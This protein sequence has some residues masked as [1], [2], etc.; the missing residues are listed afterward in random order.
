MATRI[1]QLTDLHLYA[2]PERQLK[3]IPTQKAF[4][5]VLRF[6][7]GRGDAFDAIIVTGDLANDEALETYEVLRNML[8][9][10][11]PRCRL[12]PGNHDNREFIRRVFP[13]LVPDGDGALTFSLPIG[14]WHLIGMDSH[15]P[16]EVHGRIDSEQLEW[17][18][19]QLAVTQPTILFV[20]HPP[21]A[22]NSPWMDRVG[23]VDSGPFRQLIRSSPHVRLICTG[24]LHMAFAGKLGHADVLITPSTAFQFDPRAD[25]PV[26]EILPPGFRIIRIDGDTYQSEVVRL[27]ETTYLPLDETP[28]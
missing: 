18:E 1:L 3:G 6:I 22:V 12:I 16:G 23:L 14:G 24:H 7:A 9:E 15:V 28:G 17:L 27:P 19:R 26:F 5:D 8:D 13:E 25:E 2:D 11:L 20:H 21:I 4:R 10:W